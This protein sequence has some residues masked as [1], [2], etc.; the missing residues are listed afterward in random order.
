MKI[1]ILYLRRNGSTSDIGRC[2]LIEFLSLVFHHAMVLNRM[3]RHFQK[4]VKVSF[5][6]FFFFWQGDFSILGSACFE[7]DIC[8]KL[9]R[10]GCSFRYDVT[11]SFDLQEILN[12]NRMQMSAMGLE[13]LYSSYF[14]THPSVT[15]HAS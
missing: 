1:P 11:L 13:N 6:E 8:S 15:P 7:D 5:R 10:R 3:Q 9:E 12:M 14:L 2:F 4:R